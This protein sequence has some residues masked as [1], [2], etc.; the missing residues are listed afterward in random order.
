MEKAE[1]TFKPPLDDLRAWKMQLEARVRRRTEEIAALSKENELDAGKLAAI[2]ALLP[3][4]G[5]AAPPVTGPTETGSYANMGP[6]DA[7]LQLL[8]HN[9]R[10]WYRPAEAFKAM[11]KRRFKT[12]AK[13]PSGLVRC[14][15]QRLVD[16]GVAE[17]RG[18]KRRQQYRLK[19]DAGQGA[20]LPSP[21]K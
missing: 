3:G 14:Y 18:P 6:A 2:E 16:R 13:Q 20:A 15:L 19:Q 11:E 10:K 1:P 9:P 4:L 21:G 12:N 8:S 5:A 7:V 17:C